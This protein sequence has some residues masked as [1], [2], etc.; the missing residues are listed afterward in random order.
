VAIVT[1]AGRGIGREVALSLARRGAKVVVNDYGGGRSTIKSGSI[2]VSQSVVD[3]IRAEGGE[4][5][6]EGS[7]VGTGES[8]EA[9]VTAAISAFG[10]IDILVNNAGGA[11]ADN[12]DALEDEKIELQLRSNFIGGYMLVRRVWPY[13]RSQSFGRI[14]NFMSST[15]LGMARSSAYS[16]AKGGMFGL[17]SAAAFEGVPHHIGVNGILPYAFTRLAGASRDESTGANPQTQWMNRFPPHLVGEAVVYFCS[18]ECKVTGEVF[19][20]G[21]GRVAR[22]AF[23]NAEGFYDSNL[24]AEALAANIDSARDMSQAVIVEN[25]KADNARFFKIVP[26]PDAVQAADDDIP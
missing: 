8:A 7:T 10:R 25:T 23:Y 6:A 15:I 12:I 3:E 1:G 14:V 24:T 13:M 4:A 17:T 5:I 9:I 22:T 11:I 2:S 18:P 21:A 16:A 19:S 20:V 26:W